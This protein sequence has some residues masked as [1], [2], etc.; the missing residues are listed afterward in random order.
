MTQPFLPA[1][2]G[3]IPMAVVLVALGVVFWRNTA[4]LQGHVRAGA[5]VIAEALASQSRSSTGQHEAIQPVRE[6]LPGLGTPTPVEIVAGSPAIGRTLKE[7]NLRG[8]TGAT[9]LAI[10]RKGAAMVIPTAQELLQQGDVLALAGTEEAIAAAIQTLSPGAAE[11]EP[12]QAA[13]SSEG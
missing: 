4:N 6:L 7:L 5:H 2:Q 1:F 3:A 11:P 13:E 8:L 10:Q 12:V 9:V